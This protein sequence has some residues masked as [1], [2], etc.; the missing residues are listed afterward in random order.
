MKLKEPRSFSSLFISFFSLFFLSFFLLLRTVGNTMHLLHLPPM[1]E[2]LLVLKQWSDDNLMEWVHKTSINS[3]DITLEFKG[4]SPRERLKPTEEEKGQAGRPTACRP[5][6]LLI[7]LLRTLGCFPRLCF[8]GFCSWF[9]YFAVKIKI[10]TQYIGCGQGG[11]SQKD[12]FGWGWISSDVCDVPGV[13]TN[14]ARIE[15]LAK[16]RYT[17]I[18]NG[19]LHSLVPK[20]IIPELIHLKIILALWL[21]II[22]HLSL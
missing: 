9:H 20:K 1:L 17:K 11:V 6:L 15:W 10:Y 2:R 18:W 13:E 5:P 19:Q 14:N 16:E 12:V 3:L 22:Y 7:F 4:A 21:V 8:T